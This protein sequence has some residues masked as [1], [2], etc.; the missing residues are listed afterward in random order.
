MD[1]YLA[2]WSADLAFRISNSEAFLDHCGSRPQRISI[3]KKNWSNSLRRPS[4]IWGQREN[5]QRL[6]R[7]NASTLL[8]ALRTIRE[9]SA[10]V[11]LLFNP[12][13]LNPSNNGRVQHSAHAIS[14]RI[15]SH[16]WKQAQSRGR[17]RRAL[18]ALEPTY[19]LKISSENSGFF[20]KL[21]QKGIH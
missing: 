13:T 6:V 4:Q 2:T 18:L 12:R 3:S 21:V 9:R 16:A 11:I 1:P 14:R 15:A 7:V 19:R 20:I 10:V 5:L 8:Q 17:Q